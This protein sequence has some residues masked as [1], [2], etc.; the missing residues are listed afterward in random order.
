MWNCGNG[1]RLKN[2][3]DLPS[4][5]Q[6]HH[7]EERVRATHLSD[8]KG[9][10]YANNR[11]TA[12]RSLA[13]DQHSQDL[14]QTHCASHRIPP[15][16]TDRDPGSE[17]WNLRRIRPT[18]INIAAGK[19]SSHLKAGKETQ[20]PQST[21]QSRGHRRQGVPRP[22]ARAG[23]LCLHDSEVRKRRQVR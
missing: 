4:W 20:W 14:T 15:L 2:P 13:G 21:Q 11:G 8:R 6:R 5:L 1:V 16:D 9:L 10:R 3:D 17:K 19:A 23:R 18:G 7:R 12:A 22:E